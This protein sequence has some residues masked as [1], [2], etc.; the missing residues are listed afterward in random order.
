MVEKFIERGTDFPLKHGKLSLYETNCACK[1]VK[2]YFEQYVLTLMV[3]G[4][5]TI[6][7]ENLKFEFFPGTFYIPEKSTVTYVTIPNASHYNPT[8]CLVLELKPSFIQSFYEEVMSTK[9]AKEV[10]YQGI[11]GPKPFFLSND[12]LLIEAFIRLYELQATDQSP[13]KALIEELAIK[14]ILLR[15]FHTE[16]LAL[17]K[18]NFERSIANDTIRNVVQYIRRNIDQKLLSPTLAA[19]A[20][21][22]QT[23]FF[24]AFKEHTGYS[25]ADFVLRERVAQSKIL[26]EKGAYT[27]QEIAFKCGFNSYGYFCSCFK[28]IENAKPSEYRKHRKKLLQVAS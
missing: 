27:L 20:G 12:T 19:I 23:T 13:S 26:I 2:F 10:L 3:S 9:D 14:E 16:G 8:K 22:G 6:T 7:S 4:H 1:D 25:P 17:L 21:L 28:K 11:E 24:K 18:T 15:V 5:K